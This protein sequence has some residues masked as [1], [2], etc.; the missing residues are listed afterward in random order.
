L[1]AGLIFAM[2]FFSADKVQ[3]RFTSPSEKN[4]IIV[5]EFCMGFACDQEAYRK[6]GITKEKICRLD[7]GDPERIVFRNA[8]IQ[9][10]N[11]ENEMTWQV[12][13]RQGIK[14][15]IISLED[16]TCKK[17]MFESDN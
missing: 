9:W 6:S 7:V 15:G 1:F 13:T 17:I 2:L 5:E 16:N 8:K 4:T 14:I 3:T 10:N 12:S 11:A